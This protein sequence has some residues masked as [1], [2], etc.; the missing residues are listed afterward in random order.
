VKEVTLLEDYLRDLNNTEIIKIMDNGAEMG[1]IFYPESGDTFKWTSILR[2]AD[3]LW[4]GN[5]QFGFI[6]LGE[7]GIAG[8]S[9]QIIVNCINR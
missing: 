7:E 1:Q 6:R 3:V 8:T 5:S 2:A 9:P 4:N